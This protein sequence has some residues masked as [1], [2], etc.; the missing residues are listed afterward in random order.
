[1][2]TACRSTL[3]WLYKLK[4]R[5]LRAD[6]R[7]S[8][9][10]FTRRAVTAAERNDHATTYK[11][12]Q[13]LAGKPPRPLKALKDIDGKVLT[14]GPSIARRWLQHHVGVL[15]AD[16]ALCPTTACPTTAP[17][18]CTSESRFKPSV[19][20]VQDQVARMSGNKALG[21]DG[22]SATVLRAGG[23]HAAKQLKD[24][25]DIAIDTEHVP[26]AWRGGRM[27]NLFKNMGS[28]MNCD[29]HRGL[30]IGD[31]AGKVLTGLLQDAVT[32]AYQAFVGDNQYGAVPG[33]GTAL[34]SLSPGP[35]LH[36]PL[37][38]DGLVVL[39]LVRGSQEGF[40]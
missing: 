17:R 27:C 11:I 9:L 14:D 5:Y 3:R 19:G 10:R 20:D 21:P 30:L 33:L 1:M 6:R 36:G 35:V 28:P 8:A 31:H 40:R 2:E 26:V 37:Q 22:I 13:A 16:V 24:I 7:E 39:H 4:T 29:D 32:P 38:V 34:R 15:G 18:F 25:I 12:I 23:W